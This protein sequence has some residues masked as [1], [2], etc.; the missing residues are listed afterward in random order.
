MLRANTIASHL[1]LTLLSCKHRNNLQDLL[2]VGITWYAFED[3]SFA[4][5][6]G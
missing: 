5:G 2:H 1:R 6:S 4:T 3:F